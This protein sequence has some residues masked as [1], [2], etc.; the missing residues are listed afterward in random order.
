[1]CVPSVF[2]VLV[3]WPRRESPHRPVKDEIHS[4]FLSKSKAQFE[5]RFRTHISISKTVGASVLSQSE[6]HSIERILFRECVLQDKIS[7]CDNITISFGS[8]LKMVV[9][10]PIAQ[11]QERYRCLVHRPDSICARTGP[12][13][14][15]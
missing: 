9:T 12:D 5:N 14:R 3:T 13:S 10:V 15:C 6:I 2:R 7:V 11:A 1:M 8:C 4:K